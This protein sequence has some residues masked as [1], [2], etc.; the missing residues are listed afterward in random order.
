M[1]DAHY[2]SRN[3]GENALCLWVDGWEV[4]FHSGDKPI[5]QKGSPPVEVTTPADNGETV[6]RVGDDAIGV[7]WR[8][9]V[10]ILRSSGENSTLP[11][12]LASMSASKRFLS[13]LNE[14]DD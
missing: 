10:I 4:R 5:A 3:E 2:V 9:M 12:K 14:Q 13:H 6:E 1:G 8:K 7:S 11:K